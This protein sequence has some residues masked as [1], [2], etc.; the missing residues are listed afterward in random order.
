MD[1]DDMTD[2]Y[3][4]CKDEQCKHER[5]SHHPDTGECCVDEQVRHAYVDGDGIHDSEFDRCRCG[6]FKE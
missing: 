4:K 6:G 1:N 2:L 3:A 5:Y